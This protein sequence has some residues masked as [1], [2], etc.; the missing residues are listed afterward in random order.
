MSELVGAFGKAAIKVV[1]RALSWHKR[2]GQIVTLV[3]LLV[4]ATALMDTQIRRWVTANPW[5]TAA[6]LLLYLLAA[7]VGELTVNELEKRRR[8]RVFYRCRRLEAEF[9][10]VLHPGHGRVETW[11]NCLIVRVSGFLVNEGETT[12]EVSFMGFDLRVKKQR[13][14]VPLNL[15]ERDSNWQHDEGFARFNLPALRRTGCGWHL[16]AS[17]ASEEFEFLDAPLKVRFSMDVMGQGAV[18]FEREI[19]LT[20]DKPYLELHPEHWP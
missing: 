15:I 4:G 18:V 5:R 12:P 8:S 19:R 9:R 7:A 10:P 6:V 1:S 16:T 2:A 17:S 14:W 13:R 11:T 3:V 20:A